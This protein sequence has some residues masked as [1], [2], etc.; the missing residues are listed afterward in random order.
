MASNTKTPPV[1][2]GIKRETEA[3]GKNLRCRYCHN[4]QTMI[5]LNASCRY[6]M[7]NPFVGR[8]SSTSVKELKQTERSACL[9]RMLCP[10]TLQE[11]SALGGTVRRRLLT[12]VPTTAE[13][14]CRAEVAEPR[15]RA[16][17]K[18]EFF[19]EP[20]HGLRRSDKNSSKLSVKIIRGN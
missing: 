20:G 13:R 19:D 3:A 8:R 7:V 18:C 12:E 10:A 14:S 15:I 1:I 9:T 2:A 17:R 4:P 16:F 6:S 5:A 11:L